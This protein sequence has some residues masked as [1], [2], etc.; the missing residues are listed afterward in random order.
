[1]TSSSY[2]LF[3]KGWWIPIIPTL[4]GIVVAGVM[5]IGSIYIIKLLDVNKKLEL[6]VASRT[7]ELE[8]TLEQ[9]RQFQQQL[10]IK[11]KQASLGTLSGRIAHQ[12][13]NP[14]SLID[15]N[16]SS[17]LVFSSTIITDY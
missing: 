7:K 3:L 8:H 15:L 1:M 6:K 12:I 10:I 5:I 17:S 9:L 16:I 2:L 13:K 11:E 14:L 4:F